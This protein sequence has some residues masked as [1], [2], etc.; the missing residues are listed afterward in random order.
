MWHWLGR[1]KFYMYD[2]CLKMRRLLFAVTAHWVRAYGSQIHPSRFG[3]SSSLSLSP[4]SFIF[5][6]YFLFIYIIFASPTSI[7]ASCV[8]LAR[9]IHRAA[10]KLKRKARNGQKW[11]TKWKKNIWN[12]CSQMCSM[13]MGERVLQFT[14][15]KIIFRTEKKRTTQFSLAIFQRQKCVSFKQ[16]IECKHRALV[17]TRLILKYRHLRA[18]RHDATRC[19]ESTK[20]EYA[21]VFFSPFAWLIF[22]GQQQRKKK[23]GKN[24]RLD[25]WENYVCRL[26]ARPMRDY[27]EHTHCGALLRQ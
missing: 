7:Q 23:Y 4:F 6:F 12:N 15:N 1:P 3:S 26:N 14:G 19:Q 24:E 10:P 17:S 9:D 22:H 8:E 2:E 16:K 11:A 27:D 20:G 13:R 25:G 5:F 21:R 18:F